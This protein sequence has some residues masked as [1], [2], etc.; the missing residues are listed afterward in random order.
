MKRH[1][2]LLLIFI[3]IILFYGCEKQSTDYSKAWKVIIPDTLSNTSITSICEYQNNSIWIG[4]N[5]GILVYENNSMSSITTDDGLLD[6]YVLDIKKNSRDEL[7]IF[8]LKGINRYDGV[9]HEVYTNGMIFNQYDFFAV[10]PYDNIWILAESINRESLQ[11]FNYD[12]SIY[13]N[14]FGIIGRDRGIDSERYTCIYADSK[15]RIWVGAYYNEIVL[16]S[17]DGDIIDY[18]YEEKKVE[19]V[20]YSITEDSAG[21]IWFTTALNLVKFDGINFT[22]YYDENIF[23]I[24]RNN[25]IADH[26]DDIWVTTWTRL[27]RLNDEK[28]ETEYVF[29]DCDPINERCYELVMY[30]KIME[31]SKNN[32]WVCTDKGVIMK[33]NN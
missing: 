4:T 18:Y 6:N 1:Q 29:T 8:T 14:P 15:G 26:N 20:I 3:C 27:I 19:Y 12:T 2:I 13:Y 5:Y 22:S 28:W 24:W 16:F 10:D 25:I 23:W 32:I 30:S 17:I 31:D 21:N 33:A 9:M 7:L 11:K